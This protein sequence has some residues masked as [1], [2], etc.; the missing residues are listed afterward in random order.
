MDHTGDAVDGFH[1]LEE[2]DLELLTRLQANLLDR[3]ASVP[4]WGT[5]DAGELRM[6]HDQVRQWLHPVVRPAALTDTARRLSD[7]LCGVGLLE[8]FLRDPDIEEIYVRHGEVAIERAG[9]VERG[10]IRAPDAYWE[11]LIKRVADQRGQVITPRHRAILV[12]L[13]TGE[14]FTGMLPTLSDAPTINVRRYGTKEMGLEELRSL[15]AF[16]KHTPHLTGGLEDI[17]DPKARELVAA[18]P[19]GSIQR[20]LAWVVA[21]QAGNILIAGEFSSGKTTLLNALCKYFPRQVPLAIL[22]T[23]RELQPPDEL[24]QMRAIA[25]SMLLPDQEQVAT[26][27]W[28]LNVVYTRTNPAAIALSEIVSPGE[29]MQF[30]MAANLGRRAYSTIHGGTVQASLRRLEKF[31][32]QDQSEIGRQVVRELIV[33]GVQLVVHLSRNPSPA[34]GTGPSPALGTGPSPALGTGPEEG[35]VYRFVSEVDLITGVTPE[36]QYKLERLYSGWI[37]DGIDAASLLHHA[38][39]A[40]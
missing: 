17:S 3:G 21:A 18:L 13:P 8:Q 22:E 30:L 36:G 12:D 11:S 34:L 39:E 5:A 29:A 32:L 24:Y 25:P 27:D 16:E 38:W 4:A 28:V 10:V 14:R 31:A 20:F 23:F 35:P 26:M 15:G 7:A 6:F 2:A 33:G 1:G 40:R 37:G 19:V 9:R